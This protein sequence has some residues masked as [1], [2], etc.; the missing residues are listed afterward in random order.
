MPVK[1]DRNDARG[2]AQLM[3]LGCSG[4]HSACT[5]LNA[6]SQPHRAKA[7]AIPDREEC[8]AGSLRSAKSSMTAATIGFHRRTASAA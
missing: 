8:M 1:L 6:D 7:A 3:R 5:I 2:I 4:C